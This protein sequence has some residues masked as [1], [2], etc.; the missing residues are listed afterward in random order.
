MRAVIL[1]LLLAACASPGG[2][3]VASSHDGMT[4]TD[5]AKVSDGVWIVTCSRISDCTRRSGALCPAG[6]DIAPVSQSQQTSG[7][8][9]PYGGG[10]GTRTSYVMQ[11]TCK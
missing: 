3:G 10:F 8:V 2:E 1:A 11:A 7:A 9:G 4:V 5:A 6:F